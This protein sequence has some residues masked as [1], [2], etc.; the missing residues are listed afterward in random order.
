M[1]DTWLQDTRHAFRLVRRS[2]IFLATAALS[3]S[4]GIGANTTIFSVANALLVRPL[5]GLA[6]ADRLVDIGRTRNGSGFDTFS[7]P[8]YRAVRERAT[9]LSGVYAIFLQPLPI[10]LGGRGE[11][12]RVYGTLVS[13]NYFNVLGTRPAV[14]RLL[15]DRDDVTRGGHAVA[16]ISHRLWEERFGSNPDIAGQTIALNGHQFTIVGVAP[17]GFQGT[18]LIQPDV[19]LTMSMMSEAAPRMT[20]RMFTE[21]QIVWLVMGGRLKPGV[22]VAQA[23][24]EMDAIASALRQEYPDDYRDRGIAVAHSA[25]VPG[26]IGIAAAFLGLL[27]AIAGV[28]LVI[29]CV[30]VTGMMLARATARRR[31]I[32]IRLAIG[33]GRT[34]IVGQMLIEAMIIFAAGGIGGFLLSGWLRSLLLAVLPQLPFPIA[35]DLS[36]DWR[37]TGFTVLL[38]ALAAIGSALV[39]ALHSSRA[40]LVRSLKADGMDAVRSRIRLRSAFVVGQITMSILLVIVA[41]LFFRALHLAATITPGFDPRN[42]DT[43]S[44]DVSLAG[45]KADAEVPFVRDLLTRVR[46]LPGVESA[47]TAWDLPLDGSRMG[48]GSVL[49]PSSDRRIDADWNVVEPGYFKTL[50]IRLLRGRDF[51]EADTRGTPRVAIVNNA[52]A[53]RLWPNGDALGEHFRVENPENA[54]DLTVIGVTDDVKTA[55]LGGDVEPFI[56]VP[57][58]QQSMSRMWLVVRTT[59][60]QSAIPQ[61]R[62][63]LR[64]FSPN[65]P[66]TEALPLTDLT[67]IGLVPQRV[68]AS[69]AG[70]LGLVGL[71]LAAI[72]IYGVTAY[73][74]GQ[75]TREIGI[76][77]ALGADRSRV[78]RLVLRQG[79]TLSTI[80]IAIGIVIAAIGGRFLESLLFGV[81]GIDPVTFAGASGLFVLVTLAATYVPAR[82]AARVEPISALRND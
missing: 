19:W 55:S 12:E 76:R 44:L 7:Y 80:G 24:G 8:Y 57:M 1:L 75:R 4:I 10:S 73:T 82:R 59:T 52:L 51:T 42:V 36:T 5:P 23:Q 39:P 72:G 30:N 3:L 53:R 45:I 22:S 35:L 48:L 68:A 13:G 25:L 65:L 34:R 38:C 11:A 2:P 31:E 77:M 50:R 63:L 17:R 54:F 56:Y 43:I 40:D 9:T 41:G 61:V 29:T 16:V 33:A 67:A 26:R 37:V 78:L 46:A 14:G 20:G 18:T 71:I 15:D 49:L 21:R 58:G 32:A 28:V 74:V 27:M 64:E 79:F 6:D 70:S 47:T 62:S 69:V 81:R 60:A 66:I